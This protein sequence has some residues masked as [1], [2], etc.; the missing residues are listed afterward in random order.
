VLAAFGVA[1]LVGTF[2]GG[3]LADRIG[4]T[5]MLYAICAGFVVVFAAIGAMPGATVPL[6]AAFLCWGVIGFAFYASQQSRLVGMA[7][8]QATVM[9][10]LNA[11]MIYV[12]TAAGAAAGGAVIAQAGYRGLP[13]LARPR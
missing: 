10:A 4:P 8:G 1:A 11:S 2:A 6:V 13:A 5:R 12:G 9:L 3:V 7:P